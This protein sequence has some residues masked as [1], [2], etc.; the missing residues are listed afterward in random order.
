MLVWGGGPSPG[1]GSSPPRNGAKQ[2]IEASQPRHSLL[3]ASTGKTVISP[4]GGHPVFYV[5]VSF[6]EK[7]ERFWKQCFR[8]APPCAGASDGYGG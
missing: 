6:L 7:I 4:R 2:G 3:V 8:G 1:T 5:C